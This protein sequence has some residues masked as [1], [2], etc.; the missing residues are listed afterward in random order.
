GRQLDALETAL[1]ALWAVPAH[2][3]IPRRP[4]CIEDLQYGRSLL[5]ART[6]PSSGVAA[7]AYAAALS[8]FDGPDADH[9]RAPYSESVLGHADPNP[10][11]YLFDGER[12]RIVDFEDA[13][14]SDV[15]MELATLVE[16]LGTR[17]WDAPAFLSRFR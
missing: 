17:T 15:A 10:A 5:T 3:L 8:W 16:H 1:R 13:G 2:D 9:F 6:R 12:V 4:A 14:R 7:R 11:N